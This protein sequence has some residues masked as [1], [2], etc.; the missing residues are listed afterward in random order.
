M[1]SLFGRNYKQV[2]QRILECNRNMYIQACPSMASKIKASKSSKPANDPCGCG[3]NT[4]SG[5]GGTGGGGGKGKHQ[6][7]YKPYI[8]PVYKDHDAKNMGMKRPMSPHLT[9]YAPT[10]PAMTSISQRITGCILTFYAVM[11]SAGTLFLSNGVESYVSMIQSLD[12]SR[13]S[14]LLL[15][16]I[17]GA[18]FAYHY[19]FGIRFH[20]WNA[21]RWLT[22]KDVNRS[23]KP[24][25][26][27]T[28]ATIAFFAML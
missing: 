18:P 15:K 5:A 21:G 6:I 3:T 20:I 24:L 23:V 2:L 4:P 12:L 22:M 7:T 26:I 27:A 1:L 9:I 10:V 13:F 11:I 28:I 25:L 14:I 17:L 19:F 16:I 8:A